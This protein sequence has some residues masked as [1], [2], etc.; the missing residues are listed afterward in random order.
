[1]CN[2][3]P[4]QK[5][6]LNTINSYKT[7]D[8]E[9]FLRLHGFEISCMLQYGIA[10]EKLNSIDFHLLKSQV[11]EEGIEQQRL[12]E[13]GLSTVNL[14]KIFQDEIKQSA[15]DSCGLVFNTPSEL[16]SYQ[17]SCPV[18]TGS[19]ETPQ[20][21]SSEDRNLYDQIMNNDTRASARNIQS[22]LN[23]GQITEQ[24]L[25]E[26]CGLSSSVVK[27]LANY[28]TKT[29]NNEDNDVKKLPPLKD[30]LTDFYF[31]G[32]PAAGKSCLV[33]SLL[34]Y[35]DYR[36][37]YNPDVNNPR[38]LQYTTVLLEPFEQGYLPSRTDSGFLDY[39]NCS[40]NIR[41]KGSGIFGRG[42]TTRSIPINVLDMAGEA[43][44][45]AAEEGAGLPD[46]KRYLDN[47]N[48]KAII[49]VIDADSEGS[50]AQTRNIV[51]IFSYFT[52]WGIWENTSSVAVVIT[53]AD[54]LTPYKDISALKAAAELFYN[55]PRCA[56]LKNRI[57]DLA[58][59][60]RFEVSILPYS[61][62]E[63]RWGQFLMDPSFET[64]S[65]LQ[66]SAYELTDWILENT[67]GGNSGGFKGIFT[68]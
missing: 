49:I 15:C 11:L 33:A 22:W 6:I 56:N 1:M 55:S 24:G 16:S 41:L 61:I 53:K 20:V 13:A 8:I 17:V 18:C 60:Y 48:E 21:S 54:K 34:A 27:R 14:H 35:W 10:P 47:N 68:N 42:E 2:A 43:W 62:G 37:I 50:N 30:N 19:K 4:Y 12:L 65:L 57:D 25:M 45:K 38:S 44:R 40:L 64:N 39:I 67:A 51:R 26:F 28:T 58:R 5:T 36:G 63:C 46:H 23:N 29:M 31:L 7:E 52:A 32:M 9:N 3:K 66:N 59:T